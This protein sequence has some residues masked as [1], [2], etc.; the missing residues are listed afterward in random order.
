MVSN[1]LTL[2]KS[3]SKP[4]R[5]SV[6]VLFDCPAMCSDP[7]VSR[8]STC[9]RYDVATCRCGAERKYDA[10]KIFQSRRVIVDDE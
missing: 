10:G 8:L 6:G 7:R 3:P 9:G 2:N 4:R 1:R 5:L